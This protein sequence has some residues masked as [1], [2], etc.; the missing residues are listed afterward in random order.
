MRAWISS[1][2]AISRERTPNG[3][4]RMGCHVAGVHGWMTLIGLSGSAW[5]G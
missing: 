5:Y 4:G 3:I 2:L 1:V